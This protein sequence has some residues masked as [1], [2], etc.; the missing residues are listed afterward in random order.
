MA[1]YRATTQIP[2]LVKRAINLAEQMEYTGSCSHET[3]RLLQL[4][5]GTYLSG[6]IGEIASGCGVGSA[7]IVSSLLPSTSFFTVEADAP[8]AA[9]VRAL[10]DPLLNVRVIQGDWRSFLQNWHFGMLYV[11]A[12]SSRADYPELLFQSLR[13]GSLIVLDGLPPQGRVS[14]RSRMEAGRVRDFWLNDP[15]LVA[16]EIQV[17]PTESVILASRVE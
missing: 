3:G 8:R 12:N 14:L 13:E 1:N 11:G 9:A 15:R 2:P 7:W 4:L 10:F 6:V 5:T 17:S 16:T